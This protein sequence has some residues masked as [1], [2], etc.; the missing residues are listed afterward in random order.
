ML[1]AVSGKVLST[2]IPAELVP[3]PDQAKVVDLATAASYHL[4]LTENGDVFYWGKYQ[5]TR[6]QVT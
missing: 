6:Y 1:L 5:V 4:A 2:S 3:F